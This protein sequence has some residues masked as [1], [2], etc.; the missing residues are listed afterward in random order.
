MSSKSASKSKSKKKSTR[1]EKAFYGIVIG[2]F[3][4]IGPIARY[5][6]TR[7]PKDLINRMVVHGMST[8]HGGEAVLE[9]LFGPLPIFDRIDLKYLIYSFNVKASSTKDTRIAEHGRVCSLFLLL[10]DDQE[11]YALKNHLAIKKIVK[12]YQKTYWKKERYHKRFC[13]NSI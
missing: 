3:E 9:V 12:E 2:V 8:V 7:I 1:T 5:N 6:N 11:R 13:K 10:K 4:D